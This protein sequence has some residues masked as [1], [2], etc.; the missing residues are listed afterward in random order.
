MNKDLRNNLNALNK[1]QFEY[2]FPDCGDYIQLP[3]GE[4]FYSLQALYQ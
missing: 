2:Y 1:F 4:K 3:I